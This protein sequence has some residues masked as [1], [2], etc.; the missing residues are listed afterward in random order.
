M[1]V[2]KSNEMPISK[3]WYKKW[4]GILIILTIIIVLCFISLF[5]YGV[6][7][8]AES[9]S[10]ASKQEMIKKIQGDDDNYWLGSSNPKVTIVEFADF[11]CSVCKQASP[12]IKK[13]MQKYQNDVKIIFRDLPVNADYSVRLA[14]AARCAGD[15]KL[16]WEMHDKLFLNQGISSDEE[17]INLA[18]QLGIGNEKFK[19]CLK[20]NKH[21]P[22]I[23]KDFNDGAELGLSGTP[24]WFVNGQ[25]IEGNIPY[26]NMATIIDK[27]ISE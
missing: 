13:I 25:K 17:L 11:A 8:A 3:P 26:E 23:E 5:L 4:W 1:N 22:K 24:T 20:N 12:N 7:L 14:S 18:T 27:I 9:Q 2:S 19:N 6:K 21:I 16:F 15:Q 10:L